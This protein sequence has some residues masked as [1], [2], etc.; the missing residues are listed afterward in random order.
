MSK[1][2]KGG[3]KFL[4]QPKTEVKQHKFLTQATHAFVKGAVKVP[5]AASDT[6][7]FRA[8]REFEDALQTKID[9]IN[10]RLFRVRNPR[11]AALP[12]G[13]RQNVQLRWHGS[14]PENGLNI[15]STGFRKGWHGMFGS[16]IYVGNRDK[17]IGY[18]GYSPGHSGF[19]ARP[20]LG[21]KAIPAA[22]RQPG[23]LIQV[24]VAL[25]RVFGASEAMPKIKQAPEG[26]DSVQGLAGITGSWAGTLKYDEWV[27]YNPCQV[28]VLEIH[29]LG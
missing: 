19:V 13:Q 1:R 3:K 29:L 5:D 26:F 20:L 28:S 11:R 15:L 14:R 6:D 27:V 22:P 4:R 24:E 7:V 9:I 18:S 21:L 25:G 12:N 23:M 16:G 17:A 8:L 10:P 2:G